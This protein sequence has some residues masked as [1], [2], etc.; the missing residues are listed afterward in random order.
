MI[1]AAAKFVCYAIITG[2]LSQAD[3]SATGSNFG[4]ATTAFF[5]LY[6]QLD[7]QLPG[8]PDYTPRN[9]Q[10]RIEVLLYL[11][12]VERGYCSDILPALSRNSQQKSR[13]YE[14]TLSRTKGMAIIF[15]NK[16]AVQMSRPW[17]GYIDAEEERGNVIA[18]DMVPESFPE[19]GRIEQRLVAKVG[20]KEG[21][22]SIIES[23]HMGVWAAVEIDPSAKAGNLHWRVCRWTVTKGVDSG[24]FIK[25]G[26]IARTNFEA[27][28][29]S[30]LLT[31]FAE[32]TPPASPRLLPQYH[33]IAKMSFSLPLQ[34]LSNFQL[35]ISVP[36]DSSSQPTFELR[37]LPPNHVPNQLPPSIHVK[38]RGTEHGMILEL[39]ATELTTES[40]ST[41]NLLPSPPDSLCGS[42]QRTTLQDLCFDPTSFS[43]FM[44][45]LQQWDLYDPSQT[46]AAAASSTLCPEGML[47]ELSPIG[48]DIMRF[49]S[50]P[51]P[52]H[53][54]IDFTDT[55][56][57]STSL[58]TPNS[59][60]VSPA[61]ETDSGD[62]AS[63]TT[64]EYS[65]APQS[66]PGRRKNTSGKT[67]RRPRP[68]GC[69]YPNCDRVFTSN[70]TRETHMISHRP[71]KK[72]SYQCTVGCGALFSRKHD[73]W[74]H[75]VSQHGKPTQ[76]TCTRCCVYFSSE[77]MLLAHN[78]NR[79]KDVQWKN[80]TVD[81]E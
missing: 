44:P 36:N 17:Q 27:H 43:D 74:R 22:K 77:K 52:S 75:E 81:V 18:Q 19:L 21:N 45:D 46:P 23:S 51:T 68:F 32:L 48:Q 3:G 41:L 73:R 42:P 78:C 14:Q 60:V 15:R 56:Q 65:G 1:G 63:P 40:T 64:S 49:S 71:K 76:W 39:T 11:G 20:R 79:P 61:S 30:Y 10:P 57:S 69:Q 13:R 80:H 59:L 50:S 72:Q 29:D 24:P 53:N 12:S 70:Y 47:P 25:S 37:A 31:R 54:S 4:A 55:P 35:V 38:S 5:F 33:P 7:I 8:H 9:R 26:R 67:Q 28:A 62:A 6:Y 58:P 66:R 16:E 34:A 2:L